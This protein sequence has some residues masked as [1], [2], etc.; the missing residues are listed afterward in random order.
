MTLEV[1]TRDATPMVTTAMARSQPSG[2]LA[3][4]PLGFARH[5]RLSMTRPYPQRAG[6]RHPP[7][8]P[9]TDAERRTSATSVRTSGGVIKHPRP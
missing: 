5:R 4:T 6:A 8:D 1:A 2:P 7:F 3:G 9:S